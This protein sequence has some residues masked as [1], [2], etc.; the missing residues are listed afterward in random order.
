VARFRANFEPLAA[1]VDRAVAEA[2]PKAA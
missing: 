1:Y 2:A